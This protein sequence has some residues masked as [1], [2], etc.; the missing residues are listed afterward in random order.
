MIV[1]PSR[2]RR[3]ATAGAR[4]KTA[5]SLPDHASLVLLSVAPVLRD[6]LLFLKPAPSSSSRARRAFTRSGLQ[7][8]SLPTRRARRLCGRER[9]GQSAE[10]PKC[11]SSSAR[12]VPSCDPDKSIRRRSSI[13]PR[14]G[15]VHG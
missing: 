10:P 3:D 4:Y 8:S 15:V 14:T 9:P 2:R 11:F 1:T 7:T 5:R 13:P 12:T 6:E